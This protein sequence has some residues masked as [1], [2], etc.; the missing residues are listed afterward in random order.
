MT[1]T[2]EKNQLIK[3]AYVVPELS[4]SGGIAVILQHANRLVKRGYDVT[5]LNFG[6]AV[7]KVSW[8]HNEVPILNVNNKSVDFFDIVVATH[9]S[10][11]KFVKNIFSD[12]KVYFVQSDERRFSDEIEVINECEMS[13]RESDFE[14]MT[15]AMWIQRWL[16]EEFGHD[17]YYVPNGLDSEIIHKT[18]PIEGRN[19][20]IRVLLEGPI[21]VEWKG[22]QDSY[23]AIKSLD[24]EIWIISSDGMPKEGWRCDKFFHKVPL[25]EMKNIYSSCDIF[26]KMSRVEGF[27]GPPM[28]AMACGCSVVV[29]EVTGYDEYIKNEENALVVG[30]R[31]VIGAKKAVEKLI[32]DKDLREKLIENGFT[33]AAE[34]NWN[35]SIDLLEKVIKK[36]KEEVYYSENFPQRYDYA[37]E[38]KNILIKLAKK[39]NEKLEK[40]CQELSSIKSSKTWKLLNIYLEARA[41]IL[42][43]KNFN[44]RCYPSLR[45]RNKFL[46]FLDKEKNDK[47]VKAIAFYLPQFHPIP[48]NDMWWG[49][50]F[51]EWTNVRKAK[52]LFSGH[53]QPH[54]PTAELGYYDLR[55]S[56]IREK[57]AQMAKEYGIYGFCYYYYW[58]NG[59][60][61]LET[62][63]QEVIK[64]GMPEFPFCVCWANENWTRR[65]DGR[66][67]EVLISQKHSD[68]D[69]SNFIRELMPILKDHRYIRIDGRPLLIVYRTELLPNVKKTAEIWREAARAAGIG[70]LHLARVESFESGMDPKNI[71]FDSA[72]EFAPDWKN[73]GDPI[74]HDRWSKFSKLVKDFPEESGVNIFDY[75][76]M[77]RRMTRKK[78][79]SYEL[80]RGVFPSW[81]NYAR[82]GDSATIFAGSDPEIFEYFLRKQIQ[83]TVKYRK[84]SERLIF[85]NAWNEWGE[86][87]HLEP[88]QQY[89]KGFLE[90]CEKYIQ[91]TN[92]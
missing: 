17:A 8:F 28:E 50:G 64:S 25:Y 49:K 47:E 21:D 85:L 10:T 33:T 1:I 71:G 80:F 51:T 76:E 13:Y 82:R 12:R 92:K 45:L 5:I 40:N 90:I 23:D 27:F 88:D 34:W 86:G 7:D 14:F 6:D 32:S 83:Y 39:K 31:D 46:R 79:P 56:E 22:M 63:L 37:L 36:E 18:K 2:K 55:D 38:I 75:E 48:E 4:I 57:Q 72:I 62:P 91:S 69:D 44:Y 35:R 9:F 30:Q 41:R 43:V 3:I 78:T 29:G 74:N 66:E 84:E 67:K 15:E 53:Y 73:M 61:L 65:W 24:C 20:K 26:L 87:C 16:K 19:G 70:E 11:V 42:S 60:K 59:K 77:V 89:G 81:D 58:F 68:E 54:V 52:P